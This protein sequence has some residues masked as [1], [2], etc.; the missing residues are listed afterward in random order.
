MGRRCG[1]VVSSGTT[2]SVEDVETVA[3]GLKQC[4]CHVLIISLL[5]KIKSQGIKTDK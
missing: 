3:Q 4:G 1:D 5:E 2:D